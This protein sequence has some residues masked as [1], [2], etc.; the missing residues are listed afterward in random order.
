[1]QMAELD[2]RMKRLAA[3]KAKRDRAFSTRKK[4]LL[5]VFLEHKLANPRDN[6]FEQKLDAWT[7]HE[8]P[9]F[10]TRDID[11]M[12]LARYLD[13]KDVPNKPDQ[14]VGI[15]DESD[16]SEHDRAVPDN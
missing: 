2:A 7:R 13:P 12:T 14:A 1:M 6:S 15:D 4:I 9:G 16:G 11:R 8:M 5:G 3:R 10:L